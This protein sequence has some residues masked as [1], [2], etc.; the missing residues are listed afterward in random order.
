MSN[1]DIEVAKYYK[2]SSFSSY[3]DFNRVIIDYPEFRN[4]Y[5]IIYKE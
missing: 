1:V 2:S 3:L 4:D 5:K